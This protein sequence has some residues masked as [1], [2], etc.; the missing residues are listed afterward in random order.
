MTGVE[1]GS[2]SPGRAHGEPGTPGGT[3]SRADG[4]WLVALLVIGCVV[5]IAFSATAS[6]LV[7]PEPAAA[8]S[9]TRGVP[10]DDAWI[11]FQFARNLARG[12]GFAFN[13]GQPTAGSTAPL[14]TL[15][16]AA[17]YRLGG[18]FPLFGQILSAASFLLALGATYVLTRQLTGRRWAAALAGALVAV[19]GRM[20]WAGLSALETCLFAALTLLAVTSHLKD[21]HTGH[22]RLQTAL[23]FGLAALARPEGYLLFA[24]ALADHGV[25]ALTSPAPVSALRSRVKEIAPS[26]ALFAALVLPYLVFS[27]YTAGSPLPNTFSAKATFNFGPSLDFL[28]LGSRYLILDNFLLLPF[29]LLGLVLLLERDR[30]LSA[31]AAGLPIVYAFL[32]ASLYQHGRY[33]IPI[34]PANAAIALFGLLE[35]RKLARRRGWRWTGS[36]RWLGALVGVLLLSATAWR[37]PIMARSLAWNVDEINKMHVGLGRWA[38]EQTPAN[39]VLALNDIGAITYVSQRETVDLAGLVTPEVTPILRGPDRASGLIG[40]MA[41]EGVTHVI[42]FPN[43]FPDLAA[44]SDVLT[45]VHGVTLERRTI[46]GGRTMVVYQAAWESPSP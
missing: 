15:L 14:W 35:A 25:D 38:M 9:L 41:S 33:L 28:G 18:P 42:I 6:A 17:V 46:A 43:W 7:D 27:L 12:D 20:V 16:L 36:Q 8:P 32:H 31:W 30:L 34:I 26:T 37:V 10:L 21:R 23:L 19:N 44:R 13:P 1:S 4:L 40:L 29:F 39:T 2:S 22:W 24:L 5:L 3:L 45:P 11:H